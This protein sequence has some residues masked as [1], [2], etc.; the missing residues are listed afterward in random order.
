MTGLAYGLFWQMF[1]IH[2]LKKK[3]FGCAGSSLLSAG[4]FQLW[5][6]GAPLQLQCIG[7]SLQWLLLSQSTGSRVHGLQQ[8]WDQGP[9]HPAAC[10]IFPDQRF[11]WCPLHGKADS[12][13]LDHQGS[14]TY[15]F[16]KFLFSDY[17][18]QKFR[19]VQVVLLVRNNFFREKKNEVLSKV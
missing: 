17:G 13:S 14:P 16:T 8:L 5:R 6:A 18:M 7:F 12:Q 3:I 1:H 2:F 11:S 19:F 15:A 10:G 9:S 4:F